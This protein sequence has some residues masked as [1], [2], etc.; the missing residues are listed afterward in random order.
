MSEDVV[1]ITGGTS[2]VG[3]ACARAFA[4]EGHP[5]AVL[6]RGREARAATRAELTQIGVPTST[7]TSPMLPRSTL[8]PTGSLTSSGRSASG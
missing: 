3:R 7:S 5:V 4:R 6:A 8:P 2:G 1:V